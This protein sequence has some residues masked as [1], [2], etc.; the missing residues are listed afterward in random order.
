MPRIGAIKRKDLIRHLR[1]PGFEGPY[2]G[3][4]HLFMMRE[5]ISLR[6][7][8]PHQGDIDEDLLVRHLKQAKISRG[9]WESL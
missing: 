7:P 9:E 8:N 4:K 6:I 1:Q 3:R 5:N 2:S